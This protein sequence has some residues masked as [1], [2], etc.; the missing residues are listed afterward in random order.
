MHHASSLEPVCSKR[1]QRL[2][3]MVQS[4][5][6]LVAHMAG[7]A[8]KPIKKRPIV[9]EVCGPA[10]SGKTGLAELLVS[11]RN[12]V[13]GI[14]RFRKR[15]NLHVLLG[16]VPSLAFQT[17]RFLHRSR[18]LDREGLHGVLFLDLMHR[19]IDNLVQEP[20]VI[21]CDEGPVFMIAKMIR[22]WRSGA[23]TGVDE[24]EIR[25][26]VDGWASRI[27]M[28]LL[29]DAPEEELCRRIKS[30]TKN[31]VVKEASTQEIHEFIRTWKAAL[32]EA[33]RMLHER[34]GTRILDF[35]TAEKSFDSIAEEF[36]LLM[37]ADKLQADPHPDRA[38]E[39][40]GCR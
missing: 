17:A 22:K 35:N 11:A 31:H 24:R 25:R 4:G 7:E 13:R 18:R 37:D 23:K 6:S 9:V 8:E 19:R 29:L 27:D 12:D 20:Q 15:Q 36:R 34:G 1:C 40:H 32:E 3:E 16:A 38:P 30:R 28:V 33:C 39:L 5:I 26:Q 10:G 2:L 21:L 14:R